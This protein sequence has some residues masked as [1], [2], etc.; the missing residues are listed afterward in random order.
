MGA[1]PLAPRHPGA[2][3]GGGSRQRGPPAAAPG[4]PS[5]WA[6]WGSAEGKFHAADTTSPSPVGLFHTHVWAL[7]W[8]GLGF[9]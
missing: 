7:F 3:D 1:S 5:G 6:G 4:G 8:G 9:F 2:G